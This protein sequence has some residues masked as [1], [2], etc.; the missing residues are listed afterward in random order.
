MLVVISNSIVNSSM[1]PLSIKNEIF[2]IFIFD[3]KS[4]LLSSFCKLRVH[5]KNY[6]IEL[7]ASVINSSSKLQF[8]RIPIHPWNNVNS[9]PGWGR[10]MIRE[11]NLSITNSDTGGYCLN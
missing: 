5:R 10:R 4:K 3:H 6:A 11:L 9:I 2:L 7:L 8:A 1:M